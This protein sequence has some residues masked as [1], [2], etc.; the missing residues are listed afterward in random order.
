MVLGAGLVVGVSAGC[1]G[2]GDHQNGPSASPVVAPSG[3]AEPTDEIK[4]ATSAYLSGDGAVVATVFDQAA[5]LADGGTNPTSCQEIVTALDAAANQYDYRLAAAR[6]PDP[7]LADLALSTATVV[8]D[9]LIACLGEADSDTV[10]SAPAKPVDPAGLDEA[11][12]KLRKLN[13]LVGQRQEE[14]Q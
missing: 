8:S 10:S 5:T 7:V 3:W 9:A 6:I 4:T 12:G 1:T 2:S 14:L 11:L 13:Q